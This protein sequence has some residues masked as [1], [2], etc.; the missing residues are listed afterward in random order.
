MAWAADNDLEL[1]A[2]MIGAAA[3]KLAESGELQAWQPTVRSALDSGIDDPL[4]R[5]I[6]LMV[7]AREA[8]FLISRWR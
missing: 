3:W 1:F 7:G 4:A 2:A 8:E 6:L 5:A